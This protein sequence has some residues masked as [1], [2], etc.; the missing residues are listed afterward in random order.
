MNMRRKN[1]F[2]ARLALV[3]TLALLLSK[4]R[5]NAVSAAESTDLQTCSNYSV[6]END[7]FW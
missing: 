2:P 1:T 4:I 7:E 6:R 3:A 5:L